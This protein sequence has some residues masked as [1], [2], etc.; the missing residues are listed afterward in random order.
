MARIVHNVV[1]SSSMIMNLMNLWIPSSKV[2]SIGIFNWGWPYDSAPKKGKKKAKLP[3]R[4]TPLKSP[5]ISPFV[6]I[7]LVHF[8]TRP[9]RDTCPAVPPACHVTTP[10]PNPVITTVLP[11]HPFAVWLSFNVRPHS[12]KILEFQIGMPVLLSTWRQGIARINYPPRAKLLDKIMLLNIWWIGL[13]HDIQKTHGWWLFSAL[14]T[15]IKFP[16]SDLEMRF[17]ANG[18]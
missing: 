2:Q 14:G 17:R 18:A 3:K 15:Q 8:S 16:F 11:S 7:S 9:E 10:P 6:R 4:E 1:P 5:A 12:L 13:K